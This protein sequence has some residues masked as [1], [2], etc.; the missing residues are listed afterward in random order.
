MKFYSDPFNRAER[1]QQLISRHQ[2][3]PDVF[4][5]PCVTL[6]PPDRGQSTFSRE[7][8]LAEWHVKKSGLTPALEKWYDP[9]SGNNV[10][11]QSFSAREC[12]RM[13]RN[14]LPS[15]H[16]GQ[17]SLSATSSPMSKKSLMSQDQA[18]QVPVVLNF[19][20]GRVVTYFQVLIQFG[21]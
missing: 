7:V 8:D 15:Y 13:E 5:P 16:C 9:C 1:L 2:Y 20:Q 6:R 10:A 18:A 21:L 17:M 14:S 4:E 12:S 3:K 11:S 19:V